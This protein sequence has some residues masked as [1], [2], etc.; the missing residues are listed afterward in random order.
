MTEVKP[1]QL[2]VRITAGIN[3]PTTLHN[4]QEAIAI[5]PDDEDWSAN[6]QKTPTGSFLGSEETVSIGD[7]IYLLELSYQ[8]SMRRVG[9]LPTPKV[10][11]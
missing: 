9:T 6:V 7:A 4:I 11:A 1:D 2:M 8:I 3:S 10:E 5:D